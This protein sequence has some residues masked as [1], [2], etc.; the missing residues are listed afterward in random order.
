MEVQIRC[1]TCCRPRPHLPLSGSTHTSVR[2]IEQHAG[3]HS[4]VRLGRLVSISTR[5]HKA[6]IC[7]KIDLRIQRWEVKD[8]HITRTALIYLV[9]SKH[10]TYLEF[11]PPGF[12]PGTDFTLLQRRNQLVTSSQGTTLSFQ[13]AIHC[14]DGASHPFIDKMGPAGHSFCSALD[15]MK[16]S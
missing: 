6:M 1:R 13:P 2:R 8:M 11:P 3:R 16:L 9:T 14:Q 15:L 10:A 12:E 4:N 5:K 7:E